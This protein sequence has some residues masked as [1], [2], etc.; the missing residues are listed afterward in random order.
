MR[1]K[2]LYIKPINLVDQKEDKIIRTIPIKT[3]ESFNYFTDK[4]NQNL[5][6]NDNYFEIISKKRLSNNVIYQHP[7]DNFTKNNQLNNNNSTTRNKKKIIHLKDLYKFNSSENNGFNEKNLISKNNNFQKLKNHKNETY[8]SLTLNNNNTNYKISNEAT[9]EQILKHRK[10]LHNIYNQNKRIFNYSYNKL[11][12]TFTLDKNNYKEKPKETN[13]NTNN[14]KKY[15]NK[16]NKKVSKKINKNETTESQIKLGL[17]DPASKTL[18]YKH[19]TEFRKFNKP[20]IKIQL[21]IN[22]NKVRKDGEILFNA[23]NNISDI[24]EH[25]NTN[26]QNDI[27][28]K[29]QSLQKLRIENQQNLAKLKKLLF[30]KKIDNKYIN[31]PHEESKSNND[32]QNEKKIFNEKMKKII[33]NERKKLEES[34]NDYN[35]KLKINLNKKE[36]FFKNLNK[37]KYLCNLTEINR[38]KFCENED[39]F[40]NTNLLTDFHFDRN[41]KY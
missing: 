16:L 9:M 13:K 33:N 38:N 4:S 22:Q 1:K 26:Y 10:N 18:R 11:S 37:N 15:K 2:F 29:N 12:S 36:I 19:Y 6:K 17:Y 34:I 27:N 7:F 28:F 24:N 5:D 23:N 8:S 39:N 20:K 41:N 14:S 40:D 35:K 21:L 30:K 31:K 3:K 32:Y 25:L